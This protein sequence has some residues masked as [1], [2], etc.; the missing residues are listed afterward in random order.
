FGSYQAARGASLRGHGEF[1]HSR[2][3]RDTRDFSVA[4]RA[5]T[6]QDH[7]HT[8][9]RQTTRRH[10][11]KVRMYVCLGALALAALILGACKSAPVAETK[12]IQTQSTKHLTI[13]LS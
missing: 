13:D 7:I 11:M 8:K 1:A 4:E 12:E 5:G 3:D 10:P 6:S 2:P 9:R